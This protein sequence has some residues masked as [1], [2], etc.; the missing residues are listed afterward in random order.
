[1]APKKKETENNNNNNNELEKKYE[2][3]FQKMVKTIESE[4]NVSLVYQVLVDLLMQIEEQVKK[5]YD[6][7]SGSCDGCNDSCEH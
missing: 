1:M 7:C 5:E 4:D 6:G 2:T 3:L